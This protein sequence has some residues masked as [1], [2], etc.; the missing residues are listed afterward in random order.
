MD[1]LL[2]FVNSYPKTF[3]MLLEEKIIPNSSLAANE[4]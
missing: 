2:E 4:K 3:S 1:E